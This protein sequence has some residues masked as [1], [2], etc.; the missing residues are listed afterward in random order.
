[1]SK[2]TA[3]PQTTVDAL[4]GGRLQL[5]QSKQGYRYS[6]DAVLLASFA[7]GGVDRTL[8]LGTGVGVV[9]LAM[10]FEGKTERATGLEV[11][12]P[13]AKMALA[14]VVLND[15]EERAEIIT[16]DL[17]DKQV[18]RSLGAFDRVVMNPPYYAARAGRLP[19]NEEKAIAKHKL[20]G[21]LD[22][23][24]RAAALALAPGGICEVVYPCDSLTD[25]LVYSRAHALN[26]IDLTI[27]HPRPKSHAVFALVRCQKD[28]AAGLNV[29]EPWVIYSASGK[30]SSR[31]PALRG[32]TA[33]GNGNDKMASKL[34]V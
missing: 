15:F 30:A 23:W 17:R 32:E 27:V 9:A 26:P 16:G 31:F 1:M 19:P 2:Q 24:M 7:Q 4:Y 21:G 5:K 33:Y 22:E 20:L 14:N 28:S 8:D 11:Q 6:V 25:L 29:S 18:I 10:L 34:A 3:L 13:L 12:A